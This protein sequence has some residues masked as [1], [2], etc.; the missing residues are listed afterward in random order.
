MSSDYTTWNHKVWS[1]NHKSLTSI[2]LLFLSQT[3]EGHTEAITQMCFIPK[4]CVLIELETSIFIYISNFIQTTFICQ[5]LS[6]TINLH[7]STFN[8]CE[9]DV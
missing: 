9:Y 1:L 4:A 6:T 5:Q 7:I 2:A 3:L 8:I